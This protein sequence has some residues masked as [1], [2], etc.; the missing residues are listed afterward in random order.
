MA[1]VY[2]FKCH[3]RVSFRIRYVQKAS[4]NILELGTACYYVTSVCIIAVNVVGVII[5]GGI[6]VMKEKVAPSASL[7]GQSH[8]NGPLNLIRSSTWKDR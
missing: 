7:H 2:Q 4:W 8:L 5:G 1:V 6:K 3:S